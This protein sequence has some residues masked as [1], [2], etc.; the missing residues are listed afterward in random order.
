MPCTLPAGAVPS[1]MC[2]TIVAV[3]PDSPQNQSLHLPE[4][5]SAAPA[6]TRRG[7]LKA[8]VAGLGAV[9]ATGLLSACG[10]D[11][12]SEALN[13]VRGGFEP[14]EQLRSIG[15]VMRSTL[16]RA[17]TEEAEFIRRQIGVLEKEFLRQCGTDDEGQRDPQCSFED[18]DGGGSGDS[19][20]SGTA[21]STAAKA[22]TADD[23]K[24]TD[25]AAKRRQL[26]AGIQRELLGAIESPELPNA[27]AHEKDS[28]GRTVTRQEFQ[29]QL[30][31]GLY[32]ATAPVAGAPQREDIAELLDDPEVVGRGNTKA[33][34][35]DLKDTLD[36]VYGAIQAAGVA[37]AADDGSARKQ[38]AAAGDGARLARDVVTAM[39]TPAADDSAEKPE[40]AEG[41]YE[42]PAGF[43]VSKA[44]KAPASTKEA[45]AFLHAALA[46]PLSQLRLLAGRA[47]TGPLRVALAQACAA[48]SR[49]QGQLELAQGLGP[50]A[51][52]LR[53]GD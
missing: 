38:L 37:L 19:P 10:I 48:L 49:A 30:L 1:G 29:T 15:A 23:D 16:D 12:A 27:D 34:G 45:P 17:D 21:S 3:N 28:E 51:V 39:I 36:S 11:E 40:D 14:N 42:P 26:F 43:G 50:E 25:S 24:G 8:G 22:R 31:V 9:L 6:L 2:G 52:I 20:T 7:V 32:G 41:A 53:G 33:L 4:R 44:T 18:A 46:A 13:R 35:E 47:E 5:S